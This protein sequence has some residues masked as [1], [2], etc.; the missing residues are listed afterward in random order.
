MQL[1]NLETAE[2]GFYQRIL[3][4]TSSCQQDSF[5]CLRSFDF[6]DEA[7][8]RKKILFNNFF[9]SRVPWLFKARAQFFWLIPLKRFMAI[10]FA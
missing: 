2:L 5:C 10:D 8:F 1:L 6:D 9:Q 3:P 7:S 4:S